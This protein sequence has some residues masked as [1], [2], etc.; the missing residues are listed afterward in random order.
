MAQWLLSFEYRV[1]IGWDSFVLAG[2]ISLL[3]ALFTISYQTI[4]TA[5]AHPAE[6]LKYE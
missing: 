6:T 3:I 1:V 4:K 5:S 2:S